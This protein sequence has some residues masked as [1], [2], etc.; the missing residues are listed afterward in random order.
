MHMLLRDD[1]KCAVPKHDI[2]QEHHRDVLQ[3]CRR[4]R[5]WRAPCQ[6]QSSRTA[7]V[8]CVST[9][10]STFAA[11]SLR[12]NLLRLLIC[13]DVCVPGNAIDPDTI[14]R[15]RAHASVAAFWSL[16]L[17]ASNAV[18]SFAE[19]KLSIHARHCA[20]QCVAGGPYIVGT[21]MN[22]D[23]SI[24]ISALQTAALSNPFI[25]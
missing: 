20:E 13:N 18:I 6:S 25:I 21:A 14:N 15:R 3:F 19:G 9:L 5:G 24:S 7:L 10:P 12:K 23:K 4:E 16:S 17:M 1:Y 8:T 22:R 2:L 11:R